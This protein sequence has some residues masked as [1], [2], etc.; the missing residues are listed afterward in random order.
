MV[1]VKNDKME[2]ISSHRLAKYGKMVWVAV[3]LF[4]CGCAAIEQR[5]DTPS[6]STTPFSV[7]GWTPRNLPEVFSEPS[8]RE[9]TGVNATLYALASATP[10]NP[11]PTVVLLHDSSGDW[12]GIG[13]Q[14]GQQF[15]K[16][17]SRSACR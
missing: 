1:L 17:R 2:R 3:L 10:T 9:Q 16:I 5:E 8:A 7:E 4:A 12:A 14:Q 6:I 11:V 15:A 13:A